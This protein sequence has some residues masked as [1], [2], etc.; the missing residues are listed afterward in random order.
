MG[1]MPSI[2][3][4]FHQRQH[5]RLVQVTN[6]IHRGIVGRLQVDK[7]KLGLLA[8]RLPLQL[9]ALMLNEQH[10]LKL[11]SL[12]LKAVDPVNI[13]KQGYSITQVGG[14]ALRKVSQLK[15]GDEI[16]TIL[17][18]GKVVSS[19]TE[20]EKKLTKNKEHEK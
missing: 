8:A 3:A 17:A 6:L 2:Y 11:I 10:K 1:R 14:K 5:N 15:K 19:V 9:N 12:R 16:V 18:D 7:N 4:L 20:L 13:L